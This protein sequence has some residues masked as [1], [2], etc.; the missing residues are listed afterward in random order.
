MKF[1]NIE[2]YYFKS[3]NVIG[4][5]S[6]LSHFNSEIDHIKLHEET[7]VKNE[8]H[9]GVDVMNFE[10]IVLSLYPDIILDNLSDSFETEKLILLDG[11]H[12]WK[13]ANGLNLIDKLKCILVNF[14]DVKIE[15]YLFNINLD[16]DEFLNFLHEEGFSNSNQGTI[17]I[18]FSNQMYVNNN[19]S[20]IFELY[21]FKKTLQEN[22]I[23]T[24]ILENKHDS[25]KLIKFTPLSSNDLLHVNHLLPPKSTWITPR[26]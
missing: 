9:A 17:G 18:F 14:K 13:Y 5:L 23:I 6:D 21:N 26:I 20:N 7:I 19:I 16:T 4:F 2:K 15:S 12:R 11:H 8:I 1:T 10:P 24:P 25:S 22:E 3:D